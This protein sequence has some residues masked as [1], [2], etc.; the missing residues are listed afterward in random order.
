MRIPFLSDVCGLLSLKNLLPWQH[1]IT[2]ASNRE[3]KSLCSIF[4][5]LGGGGGVKKVHYGLC[6]N[7]WSDLKVQAISNQETRRPQI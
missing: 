5:F 3:E 1:D 6:E 2:I 4:F 7:G